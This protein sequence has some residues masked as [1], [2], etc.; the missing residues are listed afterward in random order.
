VDTDYY[1]TYN[2]PNVSLV[3]IKADPLTGFTAN[4]VLTR[5]HSHEID[6]L[7]LATGF[8]AMTGA[9]TAIDIRG[10]S[11]V[12]LNAAWRDGA[13]AYLGIAIAGFPNLFAITGPGSPSVLA[14]VVLAIEQH[15]EWL[16]DLLSFARANGILEI[17]ADRGAQEHWMAEIGASANRTLYPQAN[18]WY[19]GANVP[20]KPRV[21]M[22]YL[23]GFNMYEAQCRKVAAQGYR[24]FHLLRERETAA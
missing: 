4:R 15:V 5:Q 20:G 3:D 6:T 23:D 24:G 16:S 13:G 2:R 17:E 12:S 8:D 19:V 9:L 14:N 18:S 10:R 1:E 11:G 22:P 7:V 21:F